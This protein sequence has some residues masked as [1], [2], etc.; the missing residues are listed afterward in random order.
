MAQWSSIKREVLA[1]LVL[2]ITVMACFLLFDHK[3]VDDTQDP[4]CMSHVTSVDFKIFQLTAVR[5]TQIFLTMM[6][7]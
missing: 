3:D 4:R 1:C 6:S 5:D 2:F 7:L